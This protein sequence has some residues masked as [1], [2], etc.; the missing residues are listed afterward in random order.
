[1]RLR[2]RWQRRRQEMRGKLGAMAE[3]SA[4][5]EK[6][7]DQSENVQMSNQELAEQAIQIATDEIGEGIW[8]ELIIEMIR[9]IMSWLG[10]RAAVG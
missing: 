1:M 4:Y 2:K 7:M 8:L 6:A 3:A 5:V 10:S 9:R